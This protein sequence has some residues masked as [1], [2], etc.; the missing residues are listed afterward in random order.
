MRTISPEY[1]FLHSLTD[2]MRI[3]WI[4]RMSFKCRRWNAYPLLLKNE[5]LKDPILTSIY[6]SA[7]RGWSNMMVTELHSYY[8]R[9]NEHALQQGCLLWGL[10]V[11]I[12]PSS[13][14]A[15]ILQVIHEGNLGVVTM[16]WWTGIE[17]DIENLPKEFVGCNENKNAPRETPIHPWE[18]LGSMLFIMVDAHIIWPEVIAMSLKSKNNPSKYVLREMEFQN[19]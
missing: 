13:R 12:I 10:R 5:T 7:V 6:D 11:V 9:G 16:N 8:T 18:F 19:N 15:A 4:T 14:H 17:A 1:R 3:W 2:Q